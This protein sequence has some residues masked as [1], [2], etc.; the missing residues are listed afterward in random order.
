MVSIKKKKNLFLLVILLLGA[1]CLQGAAINEKNSYGETKLIEVIKKGNFT[2]EEIAQL[3]DDG[4]D[5]LIKDIFESDALDYIIIFLQRFEIAQIICSKLRN[6][7]LDAVEKYIL[8][9]KDYHQEDVR[10]LIFI[11]VTLGLP[12]DPFNLMSNYRI[13]KKYGI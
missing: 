1:L 8:F 13:L 3:I 11:L 12:R 5:P 10:A 9:L 4:A 2:G 6:L 7:S